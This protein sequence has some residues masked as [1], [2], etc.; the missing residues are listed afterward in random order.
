[1]FKKTLAIAALAGSLG[2]S[3]IP[4][5]A[6]VG[7]RV[8]PPAPQVEVVPEPRRGYVWAPGYWD[9]R[10]G[11]YVWHRGSW[12]RERRGY[13]YNAPQWHERNGRWYREGGGWARGDRDHDG[14]PNAY[15]RHPNNPHRN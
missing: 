7:V 6:A 4:A 11:H 12:V 13:R 10:H 3:A 5:Q 9:Y 14:T 2:W 8:A 1:M 15:D